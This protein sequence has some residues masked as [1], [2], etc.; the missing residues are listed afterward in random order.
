MI[1]LLSTKSSIRLGL[2]RTSATYHLRATPAMT[3]AAPSLNIEPGDVVVL[4][5]FPID[6]GGVKTRGH[7]RSRIAWVA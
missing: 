6:G 4:A 2:P 7:W 3:S 1:A 5:G